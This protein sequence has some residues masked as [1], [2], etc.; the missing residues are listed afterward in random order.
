VNASINARIVG[1]DDAVPYSWPALAFIVFDYKVNETMP[2]GIVEEVWSTYTCG[3]TLI[4]PDTILTAGH[5]IMKTVDYDYNN[6]TLNFNVTTNSWYP[7]FESMYTVYLGFQNVA[8]IADGDT[9]LPGSNL[10]AEKR[11]VRKL[12]LVWFFLIDFKKI[13]IFPSK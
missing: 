10:F 4:T 1:G 11:H 9:S 5:C 8:G 12:I 13:K 2:D 6:Q 7:T 3:G